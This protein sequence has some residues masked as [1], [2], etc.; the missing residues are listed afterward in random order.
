MPVF[1]L[2]RRKGS[3]GRICRF[4]RPWGNEIKPDR[5]VPKG[6][7]FEPRL[8]E[9]RGLPPEKAQT[10]Q[11]DF[12]AKLDNDAAAALVS[13]EGGLAETAWTNQARNSWSKFLVAQKL[14]TPR[15]IAQLK[16]SVWQEWNKATQKI[17]ESSAALK[18]PDDP[19][20]FDEYMAP[21]NAAH[22]DEFALGIVSM[23]MEHT[24]LCDVLNKM[25][26]SV[27]N[28]PARCYSLLTSTTRMD[29]GHAHGR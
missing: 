2:S 20:A 5:V 18:S 8:Y 14:R 28:I 11:K 3:D 10:M 19:A 27:L 25:H 4:S 12:M 23:L 21:Q 26:W 22:A 15:D 13:L 17:R 9:T 16:S 1:Y 29:D 24:Q 6:T 7:A